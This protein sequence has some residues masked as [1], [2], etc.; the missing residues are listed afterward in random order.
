MGDPD[1]NAK[2]GFLILDQDL[3]VQCAS[4]DVQFMHIL[5]IFMLSSCE[6]ASSSGVLPR[7]A[8]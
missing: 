4:F 6:L 2:G 3:K 5:H 1:G 7:S 8:A